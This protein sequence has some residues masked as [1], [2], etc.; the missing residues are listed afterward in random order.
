[1]AIDPN[2]ARL[3]TTLTAPPPAAAPP[4]GVGLSD[5]GKELGGGA[6]QSS[7]NAIS[8]LAVPVQAP[9]AQGRVS[10][11]DALTD[12][13]STIAAGNTLANKGTAITQSISPAAQQAI[14]DS[15][16]SGSLLHPS[17]ISFGKHPSLAGYALQGANA[18]GQ[19][20]PIIGA[21]IASRGKALPG[22]LVGAAGAGGAANQQE[23]ERIARM[24]SDD[25]SKLPS[26]QAL[27][28]QGM[29]PDAAQ[30]QLAQATG[31]RAALTA[32]PVGA[33]GAFTEGA[34]LTEMG[35][36]VIGKVVGTSR[37]ARATAGTA[38]ESGAAGA[39]MVG[40]QAAQTYGANQATG[41]DRSL[42]E[43]GLQSFVLGALGAAPFGVAGGLAHSGHAA[44][45][46]GSTSKPGEAS[47]PATPP[48]SPDASPAT[49]AE[50][51]GAAPEP[52]PVPVQQTPAFTATQNP[53]TQEMQV[54]PGVVLHESDGAL[55]SAMI[56]GAKTGAMDTPPTTTLP[57]GSVIHTQTGEVLSNPAESAAT[58]NPATATSPSAD[59]GSAKTFQPETPAPAATPE[60]GTTASV[61][62]MLTAQMR[63]DLADRGYDS[64]AIG[65]MTPQDAHDIL[66]KP[67]A[68]AID[69]PMGRP[70]NDELD[71]IVSGYYD[72]FGVLDAKT[73]GLIAR[74][75]G[76]DRQDVSDAKKRVVGAL[77]DQRAAAAAKTDAASTPAP[78]DLNPTGQPSLELGTS[79]TPITSESTPHE[80]QQES[81]PQ[82]SSPGHAAGSPS[83]S[84]TAPLREEGS[85]SPDAGHAGPDG[86]NRAGPN[87]GRDAVATAETAG[88]GP[89][90]GT[91]QP[92]AAE[93]AGQNAATQEGAPRETA[94]PAEV[95]SS[96]QPL[97]EGADHTAEV[98]LSHE[99]PA[100]TAH[101]KTPSTIEDTSHANPRVPS[102]A[103][104]AATLVE[105]HDRAAATAPVETAQAASALTANAAGMV[106]LHDVYGTVHHV[107]AEHLAS[108]RTQLPRFTAEGKKQFGTVH[109]D[110][111]DATGERRADLWKQLPFVSRLDGKPFA[112]ETSAKTAVRKLAQS[113]ED[114][115]YQKHGEGVVA[116][117]T[118]E[119]KARDAAATGATDHS[120]DVT[121]KVT[122]PSTAPMAPGEYRGKQAFKHGDATI[123]YDVN[124]QGDV[125]LNLL[126][127][128][129][130]KRGKGDARAALEAF[131]K[132]ADTEGRT[133]RLSIAEQDA[134]TTAAGLAKLY[135]AAGF[136]DDGV[137]KSGLPKMVREAG[138]KTEPAPVE[139]KASEAAPASPKRGG[140]ATNG[141]KVRV[142]DG[143]LVY[144][145]GARETLEAYFK[146][147]DLVNG[148]GGIDKVLA[149]DWNGGEWHVTVQHVTADGAPVKGMEGQPRNHAT[150]PDTRE[151]VKKLGKPELAGKAPKAAPALSEEAA[152]AIPATE[153]EAP[154]PEIT[155][156]GEKIGG[157]RK[158]LWA[159]RSLTADDLSKLDDIDLKKL[160]RKDQV[161]K[162][163]DYPQM[164]ASYR[165]D[166]LRLVGGDTT[167]KHED[168]DAMGRV[169]ANGVKDIRDS[170]VQPEASWDRAKYDT[171]IKGVTRVRDALASLDSPSGFDGLLTKAFGDDIIDRSGLR[172]RF[173]TK[174]ESYPELM[175]LG[176]KF[177]KELQASSQYRLRAGTK[178]LPGE[179]PLYRKGMQVTPANDGTF[180]IVR[181]LGKRVL[182]SGFPTPEAA[183]AFLKT[184][185][186]E[187]D[188]RV[189]AAGDGT[190]RIDKVVAG[191]G[192]PLKG[193]FADEAAARQ[194]MRDNPD[195]LRAAVKAEP[196]RPQLASVERTGAPTR[197]GDVAP[198]QFRDQYGFKGVEFGNW[199]NQAD[200]Q[201]SL[202]HA[203]D[204]LHD[205]ARTIG[206]P[207][208]ALSLDGGLSMAFGSRGRG[209]KGAGVAHFEADRQA[210]NLTKM[211]GAGSTAHEWGH[212]FDNYFAKPTGG[213]GSTALRFFSLDGQL[214]EAM[215]PELHA[216]YNKV[217]DTM[218]RTEVEQPHDLALRQRHVDR[219]NGQL[220]TTLNNLRTA[221]ARDDT[222]LSSRAKAANE[223]QLA[224]FDELAAKIR[225]MDPTAERSAEG[226]KK[227]SSTYPEVA[228]LGDLF[229]VVKGRA[230]A[231][232]DGITGEIMDRNIAQALHDQAVKERVRTV[233]V[234]TDYVRDAKEIDKLREK[235]YWST[236]HEMFARAFE[237][238]VQDKIGAQGNRSDYLV[239]G[240]RGTY[241]VRDDGEAISAYPRDAE[242]P[243]INAAFDHLFE[244]MRSEPTDRGT[245]RLFFKGT[246]AE[247]AKPATIGD[248]AQAQMQAVVDR[249]AT[250]WN[251]GKRPPVTLYRT[252]DDLPPEIKSAPGFDPTVA[253]I[254]DANGIH[255]IADR[256]G[257]ADQL[258]TVL[259]HEA[260]GHF[261]VE[262][263]L[264]KE[265]MKQVSE[266]MQR[267]RDDGKMQAL[268]AEVHQRYGDLAPD[269][270]ASESLAVM[271]EKGMR[272]TLFG[273]MLAATRA[274]L[275]DKLGMK[276]AFTE[277]DLRRIIQ[278]AG[279]WLK[280]GDRA[281]EARAEEAQPVRYSKIDPNEAM[282]NIDEAARAHVGDLPASIRDAIAGKITDLKQNGLLGALTLRQL[283][284]VGK[285]AAV[286][287]YHETVT[288][289]SSRR[290]QLMDENHAE[291]KAWY[292]YQRKNRA[293]G[294]KLANLMH[295][296]TLA[297]ADGAEAYKEGETKLYNDVTVKHNTVDVQ[298]AL[299]QLQIERKTATG[300]HR[301]VIDEDMQRLKGAV[302]REAQRREAYPAL[303][304]R[305]TELPKAAQD[306][307]RSVRDQYAKRSDDMV[308]ALE[309]RIDS[310]VNIPQADRSV[311]KDA[312]R[313]RFESARV[314]APYFPLAR[315]G[316][317][318]VAADR[319]GTSGLP[320]DIEREFR[321]AENAAGQK[322]L[323]AA[324]AKEGWNTRSGRN[325]DTSRAL[326]G[327]SA[328]FITS[329]TDAMQKHGVDE[330]VADEVYQLYL[331][332][333]PDLS[334]RKNFIHRKGTAGYSSDALRAFA[335]NMFH[336]SYQ[337]ARL[338]HSHE[339]EAH[340]AELKDANEAAA[341]SG[342]NEASLR[343]AALLN[344]MKKRHE[345]VMA[346]KDSGPIQKLL[347]ANFMYYLG[348]APIHAMRNL[349]QGYM[350]TFPTL[351]A[352]HGW[353]R[354][355]GEITKALGQSIKTYGHIDKVVNT[356]GERL[357]YKQLLDMG[358]IDR[359]MTHD[360]AG[361]G[362]GDSRTY[363]PAFARVMGI[364]SHLFHKSE[365]MNR[366]AAGL[367]GYRLAIQDG[368]SHD[369]AVKHAADTIFDT[370]GDYSNVNR[371]RWMQ[372]NG[373]KV[374]LAFRQYSQLMT[375]N[376]WRAAHQSLKG[377]TPEVRRAAMT[378]LVGTLGMTAFF[379]GA[380]GLPLM[381]VAMGTAN[382]ANS[383]FGDKNEP[384]DAETAFKNFLT[385]HFGVTGARIIAEG[386]VN[387]AIGGDIASRV[388][389]NDMWF[390]GPDRELEG[391]GLADYWLEQI[392][393][394]VG[395]MAIM[396]P[397]RGIS[398]MQQGHVERGLETMMPDVIKDNMR[399]I[400]YGIQ[401]ATNLRGNELVKDV[402]P[403]ELAM[404]AAGL[405]P[406]RI[407]EQ[408]D[409]NN[410]MQNY[411][412]AITDRRK[413]LM[414]AAAIAYTAHDPEAVRTAN[415]NIGEFNQANPEL[416]I[417]GNQIRRSL[418]ARAKFDARSENG[419]VLNKKLAARVKQEVAFAGGE[420][421]A[422]Q[423][424]PSL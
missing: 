139:P 388:K 326:D 369:E 377:E 38:L 188:L 358:A 20:L 12:M 228:Q 164:V 417:T 375:Y 229:K 242:R 209:G 398:L 342:D 218:L 36:N 47:L 1:M 317:Y 176:Y 296:S 52:A 150:S 21:T 116:V 284:D 25:V 380:M 363:N 105:T 383:L 313:A 156:V 332:T 175:A 154:K 143:K 344:E 354:A 232:G 340:M 6:V 26:Y 252:A 91:A 381:S 364:M 19:A 109:R 278:N 50:Q 290:N 54:A 409:V 7:G 250:G 33:L 324:Y 112:S 355:L 23:S 88:S 328:Q 302:E 67:A 42:T 361:I 263:I 78:F 40:L 11:Q 10:S 118:P 243:A 39:Q 199:T 401:G 387:Q 130:E 13:S 362:D 162:K 113:P 56:E 384:W 159:G 277:G 334:T 367:A 153:A 273:R 374:I 293:E 86:G 416:P 337:L 276:L 365:V 402:T 406:T 17:T 34:P 212:A 245:T 103:V 63:R 155:D 386:P 211:E 246:E 333:L 9:I 55:S 303:H 368:M 239:H 306:I 201:A 385:Q 22:M 390:R 133:V 256:I 350:V 124:P 351:A 299:T 237:S 280:N 160:V 379:S 238:Y 266:A 3:I 423:A 45:E 213:K 43:N 206:I 119:A 347:A 181:T 314:E 311:M 77:A 138:S 219:A 424:T 111:L 403:Y 396:N 282:D 142:A 165:D 193:G 255:L 97:G 82:S 307:Y 267:L 158:D 184:Q 192:V 312:L 208:K 210:I 83:E 394:P 57:D 200:R 270:F 418:Q 95:Q 408:Y 254:H 4:A 295:D 304:R 144:V 353:G 145:P 261:A 102:V 72:S 405:T 204:A 259:A 140:V 264:G 234:A 41:E 70:G 236:V 121:K 37:L 122:E 279:T 244:V 14:A 127:V 262:H 115:T 100:A 94:H 305:F 177:Q 191:R 376:L 35:Q 288:R 128:P 241:A 185:Y 253:A 48:T 90:D 297:G 248:A 89:G 180:S 107:S 99:A 183:D 291:V 268:F 189:R 349:T 179:N 329:I 161:W 298:K 31:S 196:T 167:A 8:G 174:A 345:W 373:A 137:N 318:W 269:E 207:D 348:F 397:M 61:P 283:A 274:F 322:R 186:N 226:I 331:R 136:V 336:S 190:Y 106:K 202:N 370:H 352:K 173:N 411:Q 395:Q 407:A 169:M 126:R 60:A 74:R 149:F 187:R 194:Y 371:A 325:I 134:T 64:R 275:R 235:P 129:R 392:A 125:Q 404:Q 30:A 220:E 393:G 59:L 79:P 24:S 157:A 197:N 96:A 231:M 257:S 281:V 69:E 32:M 343:T 339:L 292:Q 66:A 420:S 410:A 68:T 366:E 65:K 62:F 84:G 215:R 85:A 323:L 247:T 413:V 316:K 203:F 286:K 132:S 300:I 224:L 356:D 223:G 320:E 319:P 309:T 341:N 27:V 400:R 16:M 308:K 346:P 170:I 205:L 422:Q 76:V 221:L 382:A 46:E 101:V 338:E 249:M 123:S 357:A 222:D 389:L 114:F 271:A 171:W 2:L 327:A 225:A 310:L 391:K 233:K 251:D 315:F 265:G 49:G 110:N 285:N 359:T 321:M 92:V 141:A 182:K 227:L 415:Q 163:P 15:Q 360:M 172:P 414:D 80:T 294:D 51:P 258:Q 28:A 272:N 287:A 75:F 421:P 216:A 58:G 81:S 131:V 5:F 168:F 98:Q 73:T 135:R 53:E 117:R 166:F 44:A 71:A 29:T 412:Q 240:T 230:S 378:Q 399:A 93:P 146:P 147:G 148:Y 120:G 260:I 198:E 301:Q 152:A 104:D 87:A 217:L 372:S 195:E 151:L 214:H 289:M 419:I 330:K 335:G 18:V 108:D 178:E